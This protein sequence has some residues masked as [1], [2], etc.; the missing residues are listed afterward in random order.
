MTFNSYQNNQNRFVGPGFGR[1]RFGRPG[2]GRP[3]FGRRVWQTVWPDIRCF[4]VSGRVDSRNIAKTAGCYTG[5]TNTI[6]SIS[7]SD[8]STVSVLK[9]SGK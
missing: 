9:I 5:S 7:Y 1:P 6:P 4:A 8:I 2:F 3:P